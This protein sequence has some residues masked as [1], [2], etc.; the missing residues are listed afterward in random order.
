MNKNKTTYTI[1]WQAFREM[2]FFL[3]VLTVYCLLFGIFAI[4]GAII[5]VGN[6]GTTFVQFWS[7]GLG[8]VLLID[9]I[10]MLTSGIG[11]LKRIKSARTLFLIIFPINFLFGL[12][13]K[14]LDSAELFSSFIF[15]LFI[16]PILWFYLFKKITVKKYFNN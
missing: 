8:L 1:A 10:I 2:P 7:S 9:G 13:F 6:Y 16:F 14:T 12:I 11:F 5:P 3:K 4:L 15:C